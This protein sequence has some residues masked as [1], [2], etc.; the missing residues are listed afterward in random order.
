METDPGERERRLDEEA[1]LMRWDAF[2]EIVQSYAESDGWATVLSAV[3]AVMRDN[4]KHRRAY[5]A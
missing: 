3:A 4:E 1:R 5:L 2:L